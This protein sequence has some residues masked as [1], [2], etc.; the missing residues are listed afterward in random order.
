MHSNLSGRAI[1]QVLHGLEHYFRTGKAQPPG[2]DNTSFSNHF[3]CQEKSGAKAT[4]RKSVFPRCAEIQDVDPVNRTS[5]FRA[6]RAYVAVLDCVPIRTAQKI[7]C[8][9][10]TQS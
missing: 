3:T 2:H 7:R 9:R 1:I 8:S 5:K 10:Y 6:G 4:A